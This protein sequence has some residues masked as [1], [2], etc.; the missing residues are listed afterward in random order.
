MAQSS[1]QESEL[2]LLPPSSDEIE[3]VPAEADEIPPQYDMEETITSG[4]TSIS[5]PPSAQVYVYRW[6]VEPKELRSNARSDTSSL[7]FDVILAL[8]PIIFLAL[9]ITAI[10]LDGDD[11]SDYGAKV[12]QTTKLAP[13]VFPIVFAAIVGS[14]MRSYAL[15]RAERSA[16][17]GTLEQLNGST[18]LAGTFLLMFA[19]RR[20]AFLTLCILLLWTIS[21]LG[22]QSALRMI[23]ET[24]STVVADVALAYMN[25]T[26]ASGLIGASNWDKAKAPIRS[27]YTTSLIASKEAKRSP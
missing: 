4:R 27:M 21:P 24:P 20:P 11:V 9:A 16:S 15:W 14:M 7:S 10:R 19:L 6:P 26:N 22:G 12:I 3:S 18:S 1:G 17:L 23:F 8:I 5:T 25:M 13:S 2:Q